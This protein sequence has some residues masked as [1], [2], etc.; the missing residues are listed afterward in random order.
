M[1]MLGKVRLGALRRAYR[2]SVGGPPRRA[3]A[4][5]ATAGRQHRA[6]P[7]RPAPA[8]GNDAPAA[9]PRPRQ[10]TPRRPASRYAPPG[11]PGYAPPGR[12]SPGLRA[13]GLCPGLRAARAIRRAT[14]PR[15]TRRPYRRSRPTPAPT[16]ISISAAASPRSVAP[17]DTAAPSSSPEAAPRSPSR[18]A[19][20]RCRTSPS[21]AASSSP[22]PRSRR[23]RAAATRSIRRGR[24]GRGVR[25]G[26]RLLLHARQHLPL[27]RG[28][29]A[30]L[31]GRRRERQDHVHV[32]LSGSGSK[33]WSGRNSG[34]PI[35]GGS[36]GRWSSSEPPR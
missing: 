26:D 10:P 13:P 11:Q 12:L 32:G 21:S 18:W 15:A 28:G 27:R 29:H 31:R 35:T 6:P 33:E 9:A 25:S 4:G 5:D 2:R 36:A 1:T 3:R 7:S 23:C 22:A 8:P 19:A 34:S 24:L 20:R 16:C 14:R 17:T 30:E